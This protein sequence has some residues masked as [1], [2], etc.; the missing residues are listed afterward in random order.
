M[1]WNTC[2]SSEPKRFFLRA[3]F[4]KI[5]FLCNQVRRAISQLSV[6]AIPKTSANVEYSED[7]GASSK[8]SARSRSVL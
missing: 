7:A 1:N 6:S 2:V 4:S 3:N 8:I 5:P